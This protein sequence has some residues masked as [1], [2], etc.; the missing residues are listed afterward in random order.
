MVSVYGP[1]NTLSGIVKAEGMPE[2]KKMMREQY[3]STTSPDGCY[4]DD[5]RGFGRG[6][7]TRLRMLLSLWHREPLQDPR[8]EVPSPML[9]TLKVATQSYTGQRLRNVEVVSRLSF[10][11]MSTN[12]SEMRLAR[13]DP[14]YL[15][16]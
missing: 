1:N 9:R 4:D 5:Y 13:Q 11:S 2:Y 14:A 15:P 7:Q 12:L 16:T 8:A 10:H 6:E 3:C